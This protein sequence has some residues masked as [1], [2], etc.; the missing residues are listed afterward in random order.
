MN[1][2]DDIKRPVFFG[3]LYHNPKD[4][5]KYFAKHGFTTVP[6]LTVSLT[7]QKRYEGEP[8]YKEEDRWLVR[9]DQIHDAS[10]IIEFFNKRLQTN[11]QL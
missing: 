2:K 3:V 8:F 11:V 4:T 1:Q 5:S 7:K 10:K 9:S 6:Y